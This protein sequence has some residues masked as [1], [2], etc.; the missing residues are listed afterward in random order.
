MCCARK[1]AT[2][3]RLRGCKSCAVVILGHRAEDPVRVNVSNWA[4]IRLFNR[5]INREFCAVWI[6]GPVAGNDDHW[7]FPCLTPPPSSRPSPPPGGRLVSPD[8]PRHRPGRARPFHR[9][10]F[11]ARSR[12][13][14]A[15]AQGAWLVR[16][17]GCITQVAPLRLKL[18]EDGIT[19]THHILGMDLIAGERPQLIVR[20]AGGRRRKHV[21]RLDVRQL[22]RRPRLCV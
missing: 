22:H 19:E 3:W 4:D 13:T 11:P 20:P 16:E 7:T 12:Q 9:H 1:S 14:V 5:G 8:I 6:P 2:A 17:S 18:S 15:L 21:E 10:L